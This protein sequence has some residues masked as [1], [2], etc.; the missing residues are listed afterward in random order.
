MENCRKLFEVC[1]KVMGSLEE[2]N[3][4]R[5]EVTRLNE[6]ADKIFAKSEEHVENVNSHTTNMEDQMLVLERSMESMNVLLAIINDQQKASEVRRKEELS[7]L[8][9]TVTNIGRD[10]GNVMQMMKSLPERVKGVNVMLLKVENEVRD[11]SST[12]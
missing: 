7:V 10:V 1:Q 8:R 12:G 11:V 3:A 2:Q 6:L 4:L 9:E 5:E